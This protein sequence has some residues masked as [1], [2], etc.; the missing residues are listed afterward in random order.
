[1][2]AYIAKAAPLAGIWTTLG[3]APADITMNIRLVNRD[4]L[5]A[6]TIS[7]AISSAATAPAAPPVTDYIEQPSLVILGGGI[8]EESG[9]SMAA[10]EVI[11]VFTSAATLT[12][13]AYGR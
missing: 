4:P 10:G 5:N 12:C 6:I 9:M 3:T 8:L 11:S 13:R 2:S 1:M 7:L